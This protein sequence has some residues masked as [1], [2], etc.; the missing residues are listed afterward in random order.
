[1][2]VTLVERVNTYQSK[3]YVEGEFTFALSKSELSRC[4][5]KEGREIT[6]EEIQEIEKNIVIKRAK[7]Y[8]MHL[9]EQMDRTS[10]QLRE[11]L[12]SKSYR[13]HV[14][15][16]ALAYVAGYGYLDD[17]RY[18]LNFINSRKKSKSKAEIKQQLMT[19][20]LPKEVIEE[21]LAEE[22]LAENEEEAIKSLA[23]KKHYHFTEMEYK[24][25]QKA[26]AFFVRKGFSYEKVKR[27][28]NE[29][30]EE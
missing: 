8:V 25:K 22:Y 26:I 27:V 3:V 17:K 5:I 10:Q 11:K 4:K 14:I 16:E 20:K 15:E 6:E 13:D 21:A 18:A 28:L 23:L 19:K 7:K 29:Q 30:E 9:L 1:M 12:K 2:L 24:E